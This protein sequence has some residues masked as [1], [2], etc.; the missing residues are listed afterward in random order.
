[1]N[2]IIIRDVDPTLLPPQADHL[3]ISIV[4]DLLVC[5]AE[6]TPLFN[7]VDTD[8]AAINKNLAESIADQCPPMEISTQA[9][10]NMA[11]DALV[12]AIQEMLTQHVPCNKPCPYMKRWWSRELSD[13]KAEKN[14]SSNRAYRLQGIPDHPVHTKH[15]EAAHRLSNCIDTTKRKHWSDWQER[16]TSNNIY[17]TNRYVNNDPTD[18]SSM[19]IPDLKYIDNLT[20]TETMASDNVAKSKMLAKTFFL[21]PPVLPVIPA[22]VYPKPL[23]AKGIFTK[24]TF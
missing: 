9:E 8:F 17:T 24:A 20:H 11:V 10:L 16:A 21:A 1:M 23:K 6:A 3:P 4:L 2:P 5:R 18:Y 7:M 15:K 14:K 22:S 19:H 13:L 12:N